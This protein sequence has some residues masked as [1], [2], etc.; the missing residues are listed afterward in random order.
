[1]E[2]A[3]FWLCLL[4]LLEEVRRTFLDIMKTNGL[5]TRALSYA[6]SGHMELSLAA[7]QALPK[8]A[9]NAVEREGG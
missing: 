4:Q 7:I 6:P 2:D 9:R 1:V 3:E 5:V 8:T